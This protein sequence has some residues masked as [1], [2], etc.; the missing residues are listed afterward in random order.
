MSGAVYSTDLTNTEWT[1]LEHLVPAPKSGGRT[2]MY[3][4]RMIISAIQY[5]LRSGCAGSSY[6]SSLN[7]Y[8]GSCPFLDFDSCT[9][10]LHLS[11]DTNWG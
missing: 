6:P 5:V 8:F 10:F 2:A 7:S 4:R 3:P 1:L 11:L 9:E